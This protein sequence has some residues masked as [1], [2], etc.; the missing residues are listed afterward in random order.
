MTTLVIGLQANEAA[1]N[2]DRPVIV[3]KC[4][5]CGTCYPERDLERADIQ[6]GVCAVCRGAA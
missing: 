2:E 4:R 1:W 3:S 6:D 5:T